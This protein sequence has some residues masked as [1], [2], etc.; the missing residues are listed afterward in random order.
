MTRRNK[1]QKGNSELMYILEYGIVHV[2]T[3]YLNENR[4][5]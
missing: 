1:F 5:Y 4:G 2:V 3:G